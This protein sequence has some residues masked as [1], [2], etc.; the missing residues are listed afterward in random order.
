LKF[1]LVLGGALCLAA[2]ASHPPTP[3]SE[4]LPTVATSGN[5]PNAGR[6]EHDQD[7][8]PKPIDDVLSLPEPTPKDEPRS[9]L[10]NPKSYKV[11]GKTYEILSDASTYKERGKASWYGMKFHGHRT[12]NGE[13][14]DVYQFTAAHKTLPLPSYVRV[15]RVDT[16]KSVIVRVNDR[17]PFHSER[18]IDLSYA[19]AAKLGINKAGVA[20]VEVEVLH[21]ATKVPERWIQLGAF[22]NAQAAINLQ[23]KLQQSLNTPHSITVTRSG[24]LDSVRIGP[25]PEGDILQSLLQKLARLGYSQPVLLAAYQL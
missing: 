23:K 22:A 4:S 8:T 12:S 21:G 1:Y 13:M 11:L 18:I 25:V 16:G 7:Y 14:Y 24:K 20:E 9:V 19:A 5:N 2:C 3:A 17:G 15:T 10:G 6:Y